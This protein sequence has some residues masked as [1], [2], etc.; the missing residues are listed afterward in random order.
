MFKN[1]LPLKITQNSQ[2]IKKTFQ[3]KVRTFLK[4]FFIFWLFRVI[5]GGK[6]FLNISDDFYLQQLCF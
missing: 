4:S 6:L 2:K 3:K 5:F 1:N